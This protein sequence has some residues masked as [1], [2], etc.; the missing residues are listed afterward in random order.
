MQYRCSHH[1]CVRRRPA[2]L[3]SS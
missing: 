3:S 1:V 2:P